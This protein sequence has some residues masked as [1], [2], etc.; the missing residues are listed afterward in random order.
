MPSCAYGCEA[1][2]VI[3][4]TSH[5]YLQRMRD[6]E[7][8]RGMARQNGSLAGEPAQAVL[9]CVGERQS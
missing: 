3:G 8:V 2:I 5:G 7:G 6:T 1:V 9:R 4:L